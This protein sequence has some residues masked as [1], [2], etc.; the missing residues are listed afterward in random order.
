[1]FPS[2]GRILY[3]FM[4]R[5]VCESL[6]LFTCMWKIT[7]DLF[8]KFNTNKMSRGKPTN[9]TFLLYTFVGV[10]MPVHC[11]CYYIL[12]L[13]CTFRWKKYRVFVL[14][15]YDVTYKLYIFANCQ[16]V[17]GKTICILCIDKLMTYLYN[18]FSITKSND[19]LIISKN[20]LA[21]E[22]FAQPPGWHD[23]LCTYIT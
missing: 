14:I 5:W 21:K 3:V 20:L 18:K 10:D 11:F 12:L 19:S 4:R 23:T 2:T 15:M 17:E 8:F 9:P 7:R 22:M 16:A 6:N 1:M 13:W